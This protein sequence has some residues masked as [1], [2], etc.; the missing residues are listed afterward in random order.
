MANCRQKFLFRITPF[1]KED[2][3]LPLFPFRALKSVNI[4]QIMHI[5]R[6]LISENWNHVLYAVK[7]Q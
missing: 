2:P 3:I 6:Q 1:P 7:E 4:P 5:A